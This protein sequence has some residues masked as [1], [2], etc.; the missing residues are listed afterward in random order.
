VALITLATMPFFFI[1]AGFVMMIC[2]F[3]GIINFL[4]NPLSN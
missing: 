3:S 4:P 2:V 1:V